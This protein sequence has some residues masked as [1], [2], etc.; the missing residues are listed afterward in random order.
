MSIRVELAIISFLRKK[1]VVLARG[2]ALVVPG[3]LPIV[4]HVERLCTWLLPAVSNRVLMDST[5]TSGA[6]SVNHVI[7]N[8]RPV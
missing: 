5:G 1:N 4:H 3:T 7:R 2:I 8:A 6:S